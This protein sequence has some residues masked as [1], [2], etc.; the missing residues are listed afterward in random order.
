[1]TRAIWPAFVASMLLMLCPATAATLRVCAS[2]NNLPYSNKAGAGYENKL[3]EFAATQL[4]EKLA[5]TWTEGR[6]DYLEKTL[7]K[8]KCDVVMGVPVGMPEIA[9]TRP[10]FTSSFVFVYRTGSEPGLSSMRDAR[11]RR[12]KIG[13]HLLGDDDTPPAIALSEEGIVDNV[14]G[15]MILGD[16]SRPNPPARVIDAVADGDIDVAAVWG[17]LGGYFAKKSRVPLT[18][19][20]IADTQGFAPLV[21]RYAIAM[22]TRPDEIALRNRLDA[23]I[24]THR[25][26]IRNILMRYG[27]PFTGRNGG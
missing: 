16:I 4:H 21:F 20:P 6:G 19:V 26:E 9:T 18:V 24:A 14:K 12:L 11:L 27:I 8:G 3:A 10:Y 23:L 1:M 17:P 25:A 15:F 22:G 7:L 5:Y 2:P 13:V